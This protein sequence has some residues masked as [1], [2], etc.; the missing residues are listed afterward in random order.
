MYSCD[1]LRVLY[2]HVYIPRPQISFCVMGIVMDSAVL[3]VLTVLSHTTNNENKQQ[4]PG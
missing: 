4:A 1:E 3:A 2:I